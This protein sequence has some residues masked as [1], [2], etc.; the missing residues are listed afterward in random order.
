MAAGRMSIEEKIKKA[1]IKL[2]KMKERY[3]AA[4]D[5]L[6]ALLE[7]KEEQKRKELLDAYE[8]SGRTHE[9]VMEFLTSGTKEEQRRTAS[10]SRRKT[11]K[12]KSTGR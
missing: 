4:A 10:G 11:A 12:K 8:K 7:K 6:K 1:E 2:S 9:E 3:D 5:E